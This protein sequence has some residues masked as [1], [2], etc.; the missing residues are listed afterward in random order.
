[1]KIYYFTG[2]GNSLYIANS[3]CENVE[4][5]PKN[6]K[7]NRIIT[8][9]VIGFVYPISAAGMPRAVKNF[10]KSNTFRANYIFNIAT[11][12]G[13]PLGHA[14]RVR[15][16]FQKNNINLNYSGEIEMIDNYVNWYSIDEQIEAFD[17][18]KLRKSLEITKLHIEN[19]REFTSKSNFFTRQIGKVVNLVSDV[20]FNENL[21]KKFVVEEESANSDIYGNAYDTSSTEVTVRQ[22]L[23]QKCENYYARVQDFIRRIIAPRRNLD[24]SR[25]V[26]P[27]SELSEIIESNQEQLNLLFT[28]VFMKFQWFTR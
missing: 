6:N 9:D 11:H 8:D 24:A 15:N 19:R 20:I 28:Q 16:F 10:I 21:Y 12:E 5:I 25:Y 14:K 17:N 18:E 4:A 13:M 7:I 23:K 3:L 1:M 2:A 22:A 27:N 26:N